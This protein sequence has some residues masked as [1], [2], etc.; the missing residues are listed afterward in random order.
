[1]V[2]WREPRPEADIGCAII[3]DIGRICP[4]VDGDGLQVNGAVRMKTTI[5]RLCQNENVRE[6]KK[7][8]KSEI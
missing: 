4:H 2:I 3:V 6:E 5:Y 1:M 7:F 8:T